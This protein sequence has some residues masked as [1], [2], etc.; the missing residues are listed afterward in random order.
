MAIV[1]FT[2]MTLM[3]HSAT[4][5]TV[6][7]ARTVLTWDPHQPFLVCINDIKLI[8]STFNNCDILVTRSIDAEL[9]DFVCDWQS[10]INSVYLMVYSCLLTFSIIFPTM[11][12][13]KKMC[14]H[15]EIATYLMTIF[16][17]YIMGDRYL[18]TNS[19]NL[20]L[21][22]GSSTNCIIHRTYCLHVFHPI[23]LVQETQYTHYKVH[24]QV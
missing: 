18:R 7:W 23:L 8:G 19:T 2:M 16:S 13:S 21:A 9:T 3:T 20:V 1:T 15:N 12:L 11:H 17:W 10:F 5:M 14:L 6:S 4:V 22:N 24:L